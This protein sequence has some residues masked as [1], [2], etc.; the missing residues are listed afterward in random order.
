MLED[1][2]PNTMNIPNNPLVSILV[3]VYGVEKYIEN[4]AVSLMEQTYENIE[5]I[6]VNDCT[7]DSSIEILETVLNRYPQR[8][9][10]VKIIIH[11]NNRGLAAARNTAVV[12]CNGD[13]LWHV[14]SDDWIP[15]DAVEKLIAEIKKS[16]KDIIIFSN[17]NVQID[18]ITKTNINYK[19]KVSYIS[20]ILLHTTAGSVWNKFFRTEFYRNT[21]ILSIEVIAAL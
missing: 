1:Q 19:D 17:Y 11:E 7:K 6:F 8:K 20:S 16:E 5:Y 9:K 4:C 12:A 10:N 14:D 18:K 2:N 15:I 21:G 3:P 13:Y